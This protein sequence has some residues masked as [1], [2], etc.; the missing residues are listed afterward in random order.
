M[1]F[2]CNTLKKH[3]SVIYL[4]ETTSFILAQIIP[5]EP[6]HDRSR[7]HNRRLATYETAHNILCLLH[8]EQSHLRHH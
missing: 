2:T 3:E 8:F 1:H 6:A 4:N 7:R 5:D